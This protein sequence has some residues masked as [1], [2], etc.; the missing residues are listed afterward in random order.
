VVDTEDND[1]FDVTIAY[2][3]NDQP[4]LYF[5]VEYF[6]NSAWTTVYAPWRPCGTYWDF[7]CT[8]E[9]TIR[10]TD[11]RVRYCDG[12]DSPEGKVVVVKTIGNNRSI[13]EILGSVA[14]LRE[15]S[16]WAR[17]ASQAS[18]HRSRAHNSSSASTSATP[19][20]RAGS[21]STSGRIGRSRMRARTTA[22]TAG[23]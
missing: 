14:G 9:V 19:W 2:L 8:S 23:T 21:R 15:G 11:P 12:H 20:S 22:W 7:N 10:V 5:W 13:S 17:A 18:T 4:D 3:C 1:R 16:P 6:I